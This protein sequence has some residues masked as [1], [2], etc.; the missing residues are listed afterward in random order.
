MLRR[1]PAAL[2]VTAFVFF[3]FGAASTAFAFNDAGW[4]GGVTCS[5]CHHPGGMAIANY[6][7]H[8]AYSTA[9]RACK[10]CHTLHDAPG[11][12]KLLPGDTVKATC[13]VCHDGTGGGGVYGAIAA[14]GLTVGGKH[15][16]ETTSV[17]PGGSASDGG[18][19]TMAFGGANSTLT[20]SDCHSPHGSD[21]VDPF[22]GERQRD[23]VAIGLF[24]VSTSNR[25]LKRHPGGATT[26]TVQYGSDWC[27]SCHQGRASGLSAVHN[28]PAESALTTANPAYYQAAAILGTAPYPTA[29]T[30]IGSMGVNTKNAGYNRAYLWPWPR[31]GAQAGRLPIC[32]QCHEDTRNVGSLT[33]DGTQGVPSETTITAQSV[34][35]PSGNGINP[36]DNPRFQ[37]FPHETQGFRLL[38]E[39]DTTYFADDL[40]M[41]CHPV[42]ALP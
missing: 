28:H 31:T 30:V 26:E 2:M 32:Q 6:G 25:L 22:L 37:N 10:T 36:T 20:C 42:V 7:P 18:S 15:G 24:D 23:G 39:A 19:A 17:V 3:L 33:A 13:E 8:G 4:T 41:N 1:L 9:T 29:T 34:G 21:C 12:L 14:R 27:L 35:G 11:G 38:V 16:I 40:C 5:S